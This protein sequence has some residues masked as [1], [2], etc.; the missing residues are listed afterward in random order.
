M[1]GLESIRV[2]AARRWVR[3]ATLVLGLALVA[4]LAAAA[5]TGAGQS[6]SQQPPPGSGQPMGAA[7]PDSAPG[8][9][10]QNAHPDLIGKPTQVSG[11]VERVPGGHGADAPGGRADTGGI[12]GADAPGGRSD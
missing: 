10:P 9:Q 8:L 4:A 6:D 3:G 12:N 7:A 5:A 11:A 2:R 1:P